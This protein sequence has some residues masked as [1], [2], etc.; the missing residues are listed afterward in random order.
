[1]LFIIVSSCL[2]RGVEVSL[3]SL[4]SDWHPVFQKDGVSA[5]EI[6]HLPNSLPSLWKRVHLCIFKPAGSLDLLQPLDFLAFLG[7]LAS[8]SPSW[9]PPE[10]S[11]DPFY[12]ANVFCCISRLWTWSSPFSLTP[13]VQRRRDKIEGHVSQGSPST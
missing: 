5:G 3:G 2:I 9:K 4:L 8:K 11:P 6:S 7:L 13:L 10:I 12:L 1:M